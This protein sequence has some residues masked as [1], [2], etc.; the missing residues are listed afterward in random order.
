MDIEIKDLGAM[1]DKLSQQYNCIRDNAKALMKKWA[2][3][4]KDI[5]IKIKT[6][7]GPD[8]YVGESY[9]LQTG[10][11]ELLDKHGNDY[12][13]AEHFCEVMPMYKLRAFLVGFPGYMDTVS[14]IIAEETN[15]NRELQVWLRGIVGIE[16]TE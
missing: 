4:T 3:L 13:S 14:N 7:I 15:V 8:E 2:K 1:A 5:D 11:E 10:D 6:S 9:Y 16:D 12:N